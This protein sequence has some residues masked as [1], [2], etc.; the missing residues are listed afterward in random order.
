MS[1]LVGDFMDPHG[2]S[3]FLVLLNVSC[4][5]KNSENWKKMSDNN[6]AKV[7][8]LIPLLA[9]AFA[10]QMIFCLN[11]VHGQNSFVQYEKIAAPE[12]RRRQVRK[13]VDILYGLSS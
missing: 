6:N 13:L 9:N 7:T 1:K 8:G 10:G 3:S 4:P 12:L 5:G 2:E 11:Q